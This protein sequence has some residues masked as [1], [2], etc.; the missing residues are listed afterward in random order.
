MRLLRTMCFSLLALIVFAIPAT[1]RASVFISVGFAPPVLPVYEQ[2][3]CP[4]P[5]LMWMPG[6]WAY[7]DDGY[8]WVPGAWV[9][10]PYA[11]ALWT[12]GYWGW[13][14]G[15]YLWHEGYWGDHIGFY[16]GVN[17]GFGYM[18]IGF[19]GGEW[20]GGHF[21]YNTA[22]V[23]VNTTI[24]HNTYINQTIVHN[25]TIVNDRH[26]AYNGG[27]GGIQHQSTPEEARA[28]HESHIAPTRF[29]QQHV[30]SAMHD[31][32]S[33]AKANGGHPHVLAA[34]KPLA[35]EVHPAP[36]PHPA[37]PGRSEPGSHVPAPI[38]HAPP[39]QH[40]VAEPR[41]PQPTHPLSD[42]NKAAIPQH[43]PQPQHLPS[44]QPQHT[45]PPPQ[46]TA[47]PPQHVT[48]ESHPEPHNPPPPPQHH[49]EP[50]PKGR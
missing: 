49:P 14:N 39:A 16:G 11:G 42:P 32:L 40:P 5:D 26:V 1:S 8:Y 13:G 2:P 50:K 30:V 36:T 21:A 27:P 15:L 12:P 10:A 3:F 23:R 35:A 29:Q 45:A 38:S 37:T 9:P 19:A 20:R 25:T 44:P 17:Y 28:M 33:Y 41:T 22:V 43:N 31:K 34:P 4:E 7:G 47:P 46:H 6:Y 48:P 24:I 18:G